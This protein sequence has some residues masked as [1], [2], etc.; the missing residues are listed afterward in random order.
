MSRGIRCCGIVS[1]ATQLAESEVSSA[2]RT[3]IESVARAIAEQ[4]DRTRPDGKRADLRGLEDLGA[5]LTRM[6][7][8][9]KLG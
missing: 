3:R 1:L 2:T 5:S 8:E 6:V 4:T 9:S 7:A